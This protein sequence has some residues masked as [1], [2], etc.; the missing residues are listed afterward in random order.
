MHQQLQNSWQKYIHNLDSVIESMQK[1]TTIAVAVAPYQRVIPS[2]F[3]SRKSYQIY[4]VKNSRDLE[5]LRNYA[6]IFSLEEHNPKFAAKVQSTGYLLKSYMFQGFLKSRRDPFKLL[7]YQT[8]PPIINYL[9]QEGIPWIGND[10][11]TFAPIVHKEGFRKILQELKLSHL[12]AWNLPKEE[13]LKKEYGDV[14]KRW[15][16]S[17]VCQPADY[18]VTGGNFF[19]HSQEDFAKALDSIKSNRIFEPVNMFKLSPFVTG[20]TLSMLGCVTEQGVLTSPLQLQLIDVSESLYGNQ[21]GGTFFGHD[22]GYRS[23]SAGTETDA[24][25]TVE[26]LGEWLYKRGYRGIFG[27]DFMYDKKKDELFPLE[28]NPRFTGAIPVYSMINIMNGVPP[29][30]FFTLAE[31]MKIPI[32]FDFEAVNDMWKKPTVVSH[33]AL[34]PQGVGTMKLDMKAGIYSASSQGDLIYKRPGAF[35]H[36]LR[37]KE[38]MII[39]DQ[40]PLVGSAISENVPRLFKL[41]IPNSI[42]NGSNQLKPLYSTILNKLHSSLRAS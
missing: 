39:I 13:I 29:I 10:P 19:I 32:D 18:D 40:I 22:W 21:P 12:P 23:W 28:C 38:E 31:Y 24:Q 33:I 34:A 2:L 4:A 27:I 8:N 5:V 37:G 17:F 42:S 35:L 14:F 6:T 36:E 25:V 11:E 41:I 3:L 1:E 15:Q 16:Q 26:V 7:F 9:N 20:D 30:D